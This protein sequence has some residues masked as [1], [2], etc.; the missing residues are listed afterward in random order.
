MYFHLALL[1]CLLVTYTGHKIDRHMRKLAVLYANHTAFINGAEVIYRKKMKEVS[2]LLCYSRPQKLSHQHAKSMS[3]K[4]TGIDWIM[5]TVLVVL[6]IK[7]GEKIHVDLCCFYFHELRP[8]YC[9]C[10][11]LIHWCTNMKLKCIF[12]I[13]VQIFHFKKCI[14]S[15]RVHLTN[16]KHRGRPKMNKEMNR[17]AP[18]SPINGFGNGPTQPDQ[19]DRFS[20]A[21]SSV[22]VRDYC[23]KG[24]LCPSSPGEFLSFSS[25]SQSASLSE[26]THPGALRTCAVGPLCNRKVT[27]IMP[28]ITTTQFS[29]LARASVPQ[30]CRVRCCYQGECA[31][32]SQRRWSIYSG[33]WRGLILMSWT[34]C[35]LFPRVLTKIEKAEKSLFNPDVYPCKHQVQCSS[36][37]GWKINSS[38][39]VKED[40]FQERKC[41]PAACRSSW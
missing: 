6:L 33:Y 26:A 25:F 10:A 13:R 31:L 1:A 34:L 35:L 16:P 28:N 14:C 36:L 7:K 39:T 20:H 38:Q 21:G 27:R 30:A 8:N 19:D 22:S 29:S 40:N 2:D 23:V 17:S 5:C 18:F 32:S 15:P 3:S 11:C 24:G 4:A 37:K 12:M 41:S 9:I